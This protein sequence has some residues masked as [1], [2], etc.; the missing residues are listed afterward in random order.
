MAPYRLSYLQRDHSVAFRR[1]SNV[2]PQGLPAASISWRRLRY[3]HA[4]PGGHRRNSGDHQI[5]LNE[6]RGSAGQFF[7]RHSDL[8]PGS[9]GV[10]GRPAPEMAKPAFSIGVGCSLHF[11]SELRW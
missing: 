2:S 10:V 11:P 1:R 6:F 8:L 7:C 4:V 5:P 3:L 9:D